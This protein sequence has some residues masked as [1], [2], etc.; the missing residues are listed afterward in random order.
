MTSLLNSAT[1]PTFDDPLEMLRACHG[2]IEAQCVTLGRLVEHLSTHGGDEQAVVAAR[3]ILRYFDTAGKNHHQDE[4]QDL[5]PQLLLTHDETATS[6]I[7]R[8]LLE[9]Q[10]LEAAWQSLRPLLVAI[11]EYNL[12]SLDSNIVEHFVGIYARHIEIENGTLL[13]LA[14]TLLN[15]AQLRQI[16]LSMA[17]RR[18]VSI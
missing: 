7:S 8:L 5:F 17:A 14:A 18:G 10:G 11:T 12:V 13:P 3:A 4:E 15:T 9:H 2:R 16:G 1:A 6:L